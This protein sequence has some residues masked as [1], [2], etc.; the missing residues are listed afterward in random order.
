MHCS[1]MKLWKTKKELLINFSIGQ[2][3]FNEGNYPDALKNFYTALKFYEQ[4]REKE[5]IANVLDMIGFTQD[6][7]GNLIEALKSYFTCL[8]MYEQ[9]GDSTRIAFTTIK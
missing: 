3:K 4:L 1:S 7:Q 9:S 5:S 8:K 2:L 6:N